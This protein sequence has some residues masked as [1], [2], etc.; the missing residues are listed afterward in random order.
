LYL[1]WL[2]VLFVAAA[3]AAIWSGWVQAERDA[4]SAA[5]ADAAFAARRT[6]EQLNKSLG[7]VRATVT[8]VAT[9]PGIGQVFVDP[10]SC[11]LAFTLGGEGDGHIDVLRPDGTVA[12]SSLRVDTADPGVYAGAPWLSAA[13]REPATTG[14]LFDGRNGRPALVFS[15][16]IASGGLVAAFVDLISVGAAA[17]DLFSGARGL[18]LVL[19]SA[20]GAAILTRWPDGARWAGAAVRDSQLRW[21]DGSGDGVDVAGSRR[22]YRQAAVDGAG[23]TVL[24]GADREQALALAHRSAR[25]QA[26]IAAV[27]LLAGLFATWVVY[28]RITRPIERL[29]TAIRG[30]AAHSARDPSAHSAR[31]PSAH[32]ARDP[33][34]ASVSGAAAPPGA[35][36]PIP[37]VGPR[38]I[39]DLAAEFSDLL[40]AVDRELAERRRAEEA[41]HEHER[42]YRQIFDGSPFP[43]YLYDTQTLAIVAAN[44]AAVDYY[45]YARETLLTLSVTDLCPDHVASA[46]GAEPAEGVQRAHRQRNRKRDGTL[47]V[48]DVTSHP[49]SF[50]GRVVRCAVIEDVTERDQLERRLR[51]SER[52][53]SLGHL[54]G[55]IAH[56]FNNLLGII[57]GYASMSAADL[58]PVAAADP[59]WRTL[60][61]DL[62]E[63]VAAGDRAAGLTRQLLAFARAD[64]VAETQVLDLNA[65]V[66]GVETMLRRTLGEDITLVTNLSDDPVTVKADIGRLEQVLVN[67][68]VNARDAMPTGGTLT[69]DTDVVAVDAH[70]AAQHPG[71]SI[72]RHARLRVSDTGSGMSRATLERAFEPFFT[73]KPKG[74][75]TGLGLATIYG[76]IT[77]AGGHAQIYSE[78]GQGTTFTALLP[79][80]DESPARVVEPSLGDLRG[81]GETVLLVEDDDSLRALTER[82]LYRNGYTVLSAAT[83]A[84]ATRLAAAHDNIDLLLT[85]VVMPDTSGPDIAVALQRRRPT[86]PV[87][88]MSGYAESILATRTELPA[89]ATLLHKPV[90]AHQLLSAIPRVLRRPSLGHAR[91]RR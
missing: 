70:I 41:A 67:L 47:T 48:V 17:G 14:P 66:E 65:V 29:R 13:F 75:G 37:V 40:A 88:Y 80:T 38:E 86:L 56:D 23:W 26:A 35:A 31:D 89:E 90:S 52:L 51:Q 46:A 53:E 28:R 21:P 77:Q 87:I 74:H 5:R 68:A 33:A 91:L 63:I 8:A 54:A 20:D 60:H 58:E 81:A 12:C 45:G 34:K 44:E 78:L 24:A 71:L 19:T 61:H 7:V 72:G 39:G 3:G 76:I 27:G 50:A 49:T 55:G 11:R 64:T 59:A 36:A 42:N 32:S 22:V 4:L 85:D 73:T 62:T 30:A 57:S 79:V 9:N 69:I 2:T 15:E 6:A 1:V 16:P 18:E 84:E 82:I 83:S 43:I 10:S 25:R